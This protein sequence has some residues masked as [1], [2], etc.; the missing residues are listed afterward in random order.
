MKRISM[1]PV[2]GLTTLLKNSS[3]CWLIGLLIS[4]AGESQWPGWAGGRT[5]FY[6][7]GLPIFSKLW[8]NPMYFQQVKHKVSERFKIK[9]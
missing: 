9:E 5:D 6:L 2:T 8:D 3:V 4:L 1:K 7:G